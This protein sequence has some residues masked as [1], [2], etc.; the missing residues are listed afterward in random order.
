MVQTQCANDFYVL[1][2]KSVDH[3]EKIHG[4]SKTFGSATV[5]NVS[6]PKP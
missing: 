6:S 3:K 5:T 2:A 1:I 4:K